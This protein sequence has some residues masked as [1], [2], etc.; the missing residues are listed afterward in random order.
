MFIVEKST[1]VLRKLKYTFFTI[2]VYISSKLLQRFSFVFSYFK[3]SITV[4]VSMECQEF[5][6]HPFLCG[7]AS[8]TILYTK[9]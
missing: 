8:S 7:M 2:Y 6:L 5:A 9:D 3:E 4:Y 1:R